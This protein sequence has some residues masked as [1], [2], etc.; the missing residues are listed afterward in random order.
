MRELVQVATYLRYAEDTVL[1][2][3]SEEK[4]Q[5][6]LTTVPGESEKKGLHLNAKKRKCMVISKK[7]VTPECNIAC[8][9]E[10]IRQVNTFKNLGCTV[11][12]DGKCD[13]EIKKRIGQAK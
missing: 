10:R 2:A 8:K 12:P 3:N 7:A 9:G 4:L 1:I 6:I 5:K 13:T 11:I